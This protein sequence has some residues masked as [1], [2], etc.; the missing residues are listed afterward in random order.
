MIGIDIGRFVKVKNMKKDLIIVHRLAE[1]TACD[2]VFS[3]KEVIE[4]HEEYAGNHGGKVLITI[5][6]ERA[7]EGGEAHLPDKERLEGINEV[8]F[9]DKENSYAVRA[10]IIEVGVRE[11]I[12]N[13]DYHGPCEWKEDEDRDD[14]CW[15]YIENLRPIVIQR[16]DYSCGDNDLLDSI[17][18]AGSFVYVTENAR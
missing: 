4:K 6:K 16:G 10:E 9:M 17:R 2:K 7:D 13:A 14:M 3:P 15:Y 1:R 11:N 18:G 12:T 5:G 8:I